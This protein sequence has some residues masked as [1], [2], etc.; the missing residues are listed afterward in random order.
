MQ[1]GENPKQLWILIGERIFKHKKINLAVLWGVDG[2]K[3]ER[4][5]GREPSEA[6]GERKTG[7]YLFDSDWEQPSL[8]LCL[9]AEAA[10]AAVCRRGQ[11]GAGQLACATSPHQHFHTGQLG[12]FELHPVLAILPSDTSISEPTCDRSMPTLQ[13]ELTSAELRARFCPLV[14]QLRCRVTEVM[15]TALATVTFVSRPDV[16]L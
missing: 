10:A 16:T 8:A 2:S 1:D 12:T 3:V 13:V 15:V 7:K 5:R 4:G 9:Q 6:G 14:L 11:L